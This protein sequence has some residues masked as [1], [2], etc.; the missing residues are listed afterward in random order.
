[1]EVNIEQEAIHLAAVSAVTPFPRG[2]PIDAYVAI[3][4]L[5]KTI[6]NQVFS[7]YHTGFHP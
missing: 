4:P 5:G 3:M 6:V 7:S 1:M 2:K